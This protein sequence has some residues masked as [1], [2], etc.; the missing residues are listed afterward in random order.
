MVSTVHLRRRR[1]VGPRGLVR[2]QVVRFHETASSSAGEAHR[3]G[4]SVIW[5]V[6][7]SVGAAVASFARS[8]RTRS[9]RL[10][11]QATRAMRHPRSSPPG[12]CVESSRVRRC[13]TGAVRHLARLRDADPRT[14]RRGSRCRP[15]SPVEQTRAGSP[16]RRST[17]PIRPRMEAHGR[18]AGSSTRAAMGLRGASSEPWSAAGK[19][20][21]PRRSGSNTTTTRGEESGSSGPAEPSRRSP[22]RVDRAM[23]RPEQRQRRRRYGGGEHASDDGGHETGQGSRRGPPSCTSGTPREASSRPV[24]RLSGV[25]LL[26]RHLRVAGRDDRLPDDVPRPTSSTTEDR[27]R[28]SGERRNR[29]TGGPSRR[30]LYDGGAA[31][32]RCRPLSTTSR[33]RRTGRRRTS[34]RP[35]LRSSDPGVRDALRGLTD[36]REGRGS[37]TGPTRS[38]H[39]RVVEPRISPSSSGG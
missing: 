32:R 17:K 20:P 11:L 39:D 5:A 37:C 26:G 31:A 18:S 23:G 25:R 21:A 38:C 1:C 36:G 34:H 14:S 6:L 15:V 9:R 10:A 27:P 8:R 30:S 7:R 33:S 16:H 29:S 22:C 24:S 4:I 13:L 3:R 2:W 19:R 28:A 35:L 12:A